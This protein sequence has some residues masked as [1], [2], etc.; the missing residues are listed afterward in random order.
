VKVLLNGELKV[1]NLKLKVDA[2]SARAKEVLEKMG[3]TIE[4]L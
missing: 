2:L 4:L 3:S 1:K